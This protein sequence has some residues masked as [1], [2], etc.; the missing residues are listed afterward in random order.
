M[1]QNEHDA[2]NDLELEI[3]EI[4]QAALVRE[5]CAARAAARVEYDLVLL[6]QE[7]QLREEEE[8]GEPEDGEADEQETEAASESSREFSTAQFQSMFSSLNTLRLTGELI[9]LLELEELEQDINLTLIRD[10]FAKKPATSAQRRSA[11]EAF[12]GSDL[13]L[14]FK[15]LRQTA[16]RKQ[17]MNRT[18]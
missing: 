17:R 4:L 6:H 8:P 5:E 12:I 9:K 2:V 11:G 15:N 13:D 3:Y 16:E 1:T 14:L 18:R 10:M 7:Q